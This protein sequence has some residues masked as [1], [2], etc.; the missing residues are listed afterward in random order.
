LWKS[1]RFQSCICVR[2]VKSKS[3][4]LRS[5]QWSSWSYNGFKE[6]LVASSAWRN[7]Y[8]KYSCKRIRGPNTI[9]QVLYCLKPDFAFMNPGYPLMS[10]VD[11][12]NENALVILNNVLRKN[13]NR[14]CLDI[15]I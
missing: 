3:M 10:K 7:C 12:I 2:W 5:D 8:G 4:M 9:L 11:K 13:Q 1:R 6:N 14:I 15:A